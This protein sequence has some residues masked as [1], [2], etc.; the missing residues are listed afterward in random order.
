MSKTIRTVDELQDYLAGVAE[1]ARHH[2]PSVDGIILAL[3]GAVVLLKDPESDLEV[4]TYK[5]HTANALWMLRGRRRL[6]FSFNHR[7]GLVDVREN[8]TRGETCFSFS[9]RMNYDQLFS[10]LASL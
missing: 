1:R 3:A 7:T 10:S 2:A 8:S 9:D 5:G 4:A 6:A